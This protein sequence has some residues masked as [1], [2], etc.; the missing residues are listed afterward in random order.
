M[1]NYR[2]EFSEFLSG[3]ALVF[4]GKIISWHMHRKQCSCLCSYAPCTGKE[5]GITFSVQMSFGSPD[6]AILKGQAVK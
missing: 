3:I 5:A 4:W 2:L 6:I 1:D